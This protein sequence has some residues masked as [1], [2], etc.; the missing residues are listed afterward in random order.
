MDLK[1]LMKES[2][3]VGDGGAG[4]PSYAKL[5]E[6]ADTLV[7]NGCE[8]EPL[9]YTDYTILKRELPMVL[10]GMRAVMDYCHIGRLACR[11]ANLRRFGRNQRLVIDDVKQ[12]RFRKLR[13]D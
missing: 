12:R 7:V 4:F 5:A 2:G 11:T 8:C 3:I 13:L 9:L 10:H 1:I 6:G